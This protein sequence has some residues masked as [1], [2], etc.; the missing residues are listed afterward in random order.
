MVG[1]L[2]S[3]VTSLVVRPS[4]QIR[5]CNQQ[6]PCDRKCL[7]S[8]SDQESTT[9]AP[10]ETH[11]KPVPTNGIFWPARMYPRI[12]CRTKSSRAD[13]GA[14]ARRAWHQDPLNLMRSSA[15]IIRSGRKHAKPPFFSTTAHTSEPVANGLR[16]TRTA[17]PAEM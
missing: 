10:P 8:V 2:L 7:P 17:H 15:N 9:A 16:T 4:E 11:P 3:V 5:D 6:E 13:L 1:M 12:D 14:R